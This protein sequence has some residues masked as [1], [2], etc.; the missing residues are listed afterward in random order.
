M[1]DF[2]RKKLR[3]LKWDTSPVMYPYGVTAFVLGT[4]KF[5]CQMTDA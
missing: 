3:S 1:I 5:A 2:S 4:N